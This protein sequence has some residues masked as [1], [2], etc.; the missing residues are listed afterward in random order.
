VAHA[1]G[2]PWYRAA[3]AGVDVDGAR[4]LRELPLLDKPRAAEVQEELVVATVR[5]APASFGAGVVSSATTRKGRPL[6]IQ[7]AEDDVLA[8]RG[9][10]DPVEL[11][12]LEIVSPRHGLRPPGGAR[13]LVMAALH[14][15]TVDVTA[16]LLA[17]RAFD[18][19]VAPLSTLKWITA[20]LPPATLRSFGVEVLGATGYPVTAHTRA[21]VE[22]AWRAIVLDNWS[23]SELR[24]HAHP[25]ACGF[26]HWV[27]AP[28]WCELVDPLTTKSVA[29]RTGALGELVVT[30]VLPHGARMPLVRYRSGDIVEVGP[31][32][33]RTGSRGVRF[34]GRVSTSLLAIHRGRTLY[35][36]LSRDLL[37]VAEAHDDVAFEPHPAERLGLVS[38]ASFRIGVPKVKVVDGFVAAEVVFDPR[39]DAARARNV[40]RALRRACAKDVAIELLPPATL[41]FT[42][43]ARKL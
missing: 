15:N 42:R 19:V 8:P 33:R 22:G 43:E 6:R 10:P 38:S 11:R 36:A 41:D 25:C 18:T 35:R 16:D 29:A 28:V 12:T 21:V 5:P 3:F 40:T 27:G 2:A 30:T 14:P 26:A 23:M 32:C 24:G 34:R 20:A 39:H 4:A 1:R 31:V 9:A 13:T 7:L 17:S 37:E